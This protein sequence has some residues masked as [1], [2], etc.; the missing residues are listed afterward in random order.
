M[1]EISDKQ[2]GR[3]LGTLSDEQFQFL[4]DQLEEESAADDDYYLNRTTVDLLE[5]QGADPALVAL[6][7]TALGAGEETEIRWRRT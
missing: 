2:T 6:L 1:I 7:R 4:S 5:E 3:S